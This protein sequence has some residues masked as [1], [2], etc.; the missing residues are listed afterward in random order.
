MTPSN[1]EYSEILLSHGQIAKV[2][3]SDFEWL[4]TI[5]WHAIWN[6]NTGSYY[7]AAT[8]IENGRRGLIRMHRLIL[9][10]HYGDALQADH[11]NR[12]TLDNRRENLRRATRSQNIMNQ[13]NKKVD[14]ESEGIRH[15][16]NWI[17][18]FRHLGKKIHVGTYRS[19]DEARQ[20]RKA[21]MAEFGLTG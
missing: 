16:D 11:I 5:K 7:A 2:S 4:S 15:I 18:E 13:R 6:K 12:D 10:L 21:K 17:S 9:D 1:Q 14:S 8:T 3:D 20:A 19:E